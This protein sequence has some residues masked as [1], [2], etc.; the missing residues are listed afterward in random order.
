LEQGV[1]AEGEEIGCAGAGSGEVDGA[2]LGF[3][4]HYSPTFG[5]GLVRA[6][7]RA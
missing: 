1:G 5:R 6:C 7:S 3:A 2:G 4:V